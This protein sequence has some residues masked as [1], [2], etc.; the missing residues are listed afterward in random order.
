M[1]FVFKRL[2][3]P[4]KEDL[5]FTWDS[6]P[7]TVKSGSGEMFPDFVA[8]LGARRLADREGI[9]SFKKDDYIKSLLS[10]VGEIQDKVIPTLK[11]EIEEAKKQIEVKEFEDLKKLEDKPWCDTCNS[12]GVRHKKECPKYK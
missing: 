11:Q 8:K 5:T 10:D 4:T 2:Y 3:N 12:K 6:E 7:Y 9:K 1:K